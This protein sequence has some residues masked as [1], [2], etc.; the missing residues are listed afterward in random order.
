MGATIHLHY[1]M[2]EF[3]GWT[4]IQDKNEKC[5]KC[6]MEEKDKEGCCKDEHKQVKLKTDHQKAGVTAFLNVVTSPVIIN[7]APD[8]N[9]LPFLGIAE[10]YSPCHAPPD[11]GDIK[12]HILHGVFLI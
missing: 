12:L 9:F 3:V 4:L 5:G 2:N 8:F 7:P 6:G 11:I 10:R 1:C